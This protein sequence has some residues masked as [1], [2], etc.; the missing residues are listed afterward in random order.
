MPIS[1]ACGSARC[2]VTLYPSGYAVAWLTVVTPTEGGP[3]HR[4]S[5]RWGLTASPEAMNSPSE[6]VQAA[7]EARPPA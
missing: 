6:L 2:V 4:H 3:R 1:S 5:Q 7:L